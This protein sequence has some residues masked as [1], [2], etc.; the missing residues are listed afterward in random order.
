MPLVDYIALTV[1]LVNM[2]EIVR[3]A[4]RL[5]LTIIGTCPQSFT[6]V[7]VVP[8]LT[9]QWIR[10][11]IFPRYEVK[12]SRAWKICAE[13]GCSYNAYLRYVP[14]LDKPFAWLLCVADQV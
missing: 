5:T 6:I 12:R 9:L 8:S 14:R 10:A 2:A 7:S 13:H 3:L 11:C 4:E 1:Y